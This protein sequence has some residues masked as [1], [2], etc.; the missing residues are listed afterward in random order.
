[1]GAGRGVQGG[2]LAPPGKSKLIYGYF[3]IFSKITIV[4]YNFSQEM[5]K[6]CLNFTIVDM[7][8]EKILIG[9]FSDKQ[10]SQFWY[11]RLFLHPCGRLTIILAPPWKTF[12]RRPWSCPTT[13]WVP[14]TTFSVCVVIVQHMSASPL[15]LHIYVCYRLSVFCFQ[16]LVQKRISYMRWWWRSVLT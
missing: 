4:K 16:T 2:A 9:R 1:M 3:D 6:K 10:I 14:K 12:C 7:F 13:A 15:E 5:L 8:L 11:Q